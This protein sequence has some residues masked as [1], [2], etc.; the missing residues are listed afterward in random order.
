MNQSEKSLVSIIIPTKNSVRT[1]EACLK[2]C[3]EQTYPHIE[4]IVVDNFST[5]GT[6]KITSQYTHKVFQKWPERSAQRNYGVSKCSGEYV[7]IIDSDMKLS[8]T[9]IQDCMKQIES[10]TGYKGL[11]IPEESFGE[12][13]WA[14]CKKL[15][16][17]F[18]VGIDWMEAARFFDRNTF[19]EVW[20][21]DE[22]NIGTEDYDLPQR[23]QGIYDKSC[24]GRIDSYIYH[25][26]WKLS[27]WRTCQKKFYYGQ[28]LNYYKSQTTNKDNFSN[29][30]SIL[31][32]YLLFLKKPKQLL[33]NPI[34][35]L[36]MLWMK[37]IE[38]I[39]GASGYL[40]G[41]IRK[42]DNIY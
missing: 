2:S 37:S 31:N 23:I 22:K 28:R 15:E 8:P 11:V 34:I 38:M 25:D 13:F 4:I 39:S 30:S 19:N 10:N 6:D 17:S 14:K 7:L 12:W 35:G 18:Y 27:L 24:I 3:K 26:E 40:L 1:I 20:W 9:V 36:G 41:K 29:Q 21:Y 5:D 16:R 42:V 32:R 33:Y